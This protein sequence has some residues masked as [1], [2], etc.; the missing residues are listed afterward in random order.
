MI[1]RI[2]LLFA[3]LMLGPNGASAQEHVGHAVGEC[4]GVI[5]GYNGRQYQCER[6]RLP[7]CNQDG[8]ECVC[9]AR[10]ECGAK[11]NEPY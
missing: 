2:G 9:L 6:D 10:R 1:F 3:A 7:V 8:R 4:G 5:T 11:Q